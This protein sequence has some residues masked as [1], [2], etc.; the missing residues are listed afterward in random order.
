MKTQN[1]SNLEQ[2]TM[3]IVWRLGECTVRDVMKAR[4][5]KKNLAYTTIATIVDR[6]YTKEFLKRNQK[7]KQYVYM[8][9]ISREEFSK[10]VA[11][12]FIH[13]FMKNFGDVAVASFAESIEELPEKKRRSIVEKIQLYEK[14]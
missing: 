9:R 5:G 1:L 6:L 4:S 7:G 3:D 14:K 11:T 12:H 13:R 10:N 8:P 2:E